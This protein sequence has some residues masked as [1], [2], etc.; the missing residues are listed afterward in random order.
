MCLFLILSIILVLSVLD[1]IYCPCFC[2]TCLFL[3]SSIPLVL[4]SV[5]VVLK[6]PAFVTC[7]CSGV[8][9][10]L[11]LIRCIALIAL[12]LSRSRCRELREY[13]AATWTLNK[14]KDTSNKQWTM[15]NEWYID[16]YDMIW[17]G[18]D[19][20][21]WIWMSISNHNHPYLL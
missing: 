9:N 7:V 1:V 13:I 15:D 17:I 4:S 6:W 12:A 18:V 8:I 3:I 10:A 21:G 14:L 2:Q 16:G 19:G 20:R 11:G 5:L